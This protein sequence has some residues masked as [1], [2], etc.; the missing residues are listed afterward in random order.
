MTDEIVRRLW[1]LWYEIMERVCSVIGHH[2][3]PVYQ[4]PQFRHCKR[5]GMTRDAGGVWT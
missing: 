5:C 1:Q 2:P 4:W 3:M